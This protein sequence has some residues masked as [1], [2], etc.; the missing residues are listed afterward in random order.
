MPKHS[1]TL[2]STLDSIEKAVDLA[3]KVAGNMK[4]NETEV[5]SFAIAV[6]EAVTNAIKHGNR[7]DKSKKVYLNI[8]VENDK[9]T[10]SVKDSGKGF[11]PDE[12]LDPTKEENITK[13][14]GRGV[15]YVSVSIPIWTKSHLTCLKA[16][17]RSSNSTKPLSMPRMS[18]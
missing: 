13:S 1:L 15:F 4:L 17:T 18:W 8:D 10:V 3:E 14:S 7:E 2:P 9:I 6:S 12:L 11:N 5:S 16:R